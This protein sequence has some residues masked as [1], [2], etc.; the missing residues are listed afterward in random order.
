MSKSEIQSWLSSASSSDENGEPPSVLSWQRDRVLN[1]WP[2][3]LEFA[4]NRLLASKTKVRVQF[5]QEELLS[6]AKHGG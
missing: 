5:L 3:A 6:L 2:Q 1:E 4:Q